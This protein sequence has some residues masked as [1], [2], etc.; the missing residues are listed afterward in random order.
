MW[1]AYLVELSR[2]H[3]CLTD[4][5]ETVVSFHAEVRRR[6]FLPDCF[7]PSLPVLKSEPNSAP[8]AKSQHGSVSPTLFALSVNCLFGRMGG[9]SRRRYLDE[10]VAF[11]K[12][13]TDYIGS[14]WIFTCRL[15]TA[16]CRCVNPR[17]GK[18][19]GPCVSFVF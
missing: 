3:G 17:A 6:A 18:Q 10:G 11:C 1:I 2:E 9:T 7:H 19:F 8:W 12:V 13:L 5:R 14:D 15:R 16:R 4:S